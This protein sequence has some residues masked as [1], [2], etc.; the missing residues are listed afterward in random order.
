MQSLLLF[1]SP[2]PIAILKFL[3]YI[4][5]ALSAQWAF[6]DQWV[7]L[8][9]DMVTNAELGLAEDHFSHPEVSGLV[10]SSDRRCKLSTGLVFGSPGQIRL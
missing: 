9:S 1:Y 3:R 2:P 4:L 10:C 6:G 7:D 5:F 8:D